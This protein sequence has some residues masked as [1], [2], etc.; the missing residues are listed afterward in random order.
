MNIPERT[1]WIEYP[2]STS[3]PWNQ[4]AIHA[5]D[6]YPHCLLLVESRSGRFVQDDG[7]TSL[8]R[9]LL[10]LVAL[11]LRPAGGGREGH[12][13]VHHDLVHRHFD[14]TLCRPFGVLSWFA[15][16]NEIMR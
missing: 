12:L 8:G 15:E 7:F 6:A 10:L 3:S 4:E 11:L 2:R 16:Y 13:L 9:S 14:P 1:G 5:L